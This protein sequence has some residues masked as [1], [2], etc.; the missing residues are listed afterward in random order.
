MTNEQREK[1]QQIL[2]ALDENALIALK[3]KG[4]V[5][6]AAKDLADGG[7]THEEID[8]AILVHGQGWTVT[9]PP[10]GP[11]RATDDTKATGI[12]RQIL[13]AILYLQQEWLTDQP[14]EKSIGPDESLEEAILA[15][16]TDDLQKWGGKTT[17]REAM[18]LTENATLEV[19]HTSGL[20]LRLVKHE[21]EARL[22]PGHSSTLPAKK[23]LDQ[24][25]T[26]APKSQHKKWAIVAV[27]AFQRSRGIQATLPE[28]SSKKTSEGP[29]TREEILL[30]E[31]GRAHV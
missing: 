30:S 19:E 6:R 2:A 29:R 31:I 13:T 17:L 25:L 27:L 23:L 16:T 8:E 26:T 9:M 4:L 18:P 21:I 15:I 1:L 11:T 14:G 10:E 3:N 12:T 22:L 5:R 24:I 20:A 28:A 7:L